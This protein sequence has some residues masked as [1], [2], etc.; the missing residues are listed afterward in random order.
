MCVPVESSEAT[1]VPG[2]ESEFPTYL[3][4][5]VNGCMCMCVHVCMH[6]TAHVWRLRDNLCA[7]GGDANVCSVEG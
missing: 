4:S 3:G 1:A 2:P 7:T 5:Q 6:A